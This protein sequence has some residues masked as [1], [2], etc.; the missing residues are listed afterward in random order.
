VGIM[1]R[2]NIARRVWS[3]WEGST[4]VGGKTSIELGYGDTSSWNNMCENCLATRRPFTMPESYTLTNNGAIYGGNYSNFEA[5]QPYSLFSSANNDEC[6]SNRILGSMAYLQSKDFLVYGTN[7]TAMVT[8]RRPSCQS[9][10]HVL[11]FNGLT[12]SQNLQGAGGSNGPVM[13]FWLGDANVTSGNV[14]EHVTSITNPL[15]NIIASDW[16]VTNYIKATSVSSVDSQ[17]AN[18]FTGTAGAQLC[19]R[20]VNG[21]VT[22]VPLWPWP[23]NERIRAATTM[24]GAYSGPCLNCSGGRQARVVTDVTADVEAMLGTIPSQCRTSGSPTQGYT[25]CGFEYEHCNFQG[26]KE[27]RYGADGVFVSKILTDGT[28]CTNAV[29][30]DPVFGATKYC[31]FRDVV[32]PLPTVD[33]IAPTVTI[34]SPP[35][36]TVIQQSQ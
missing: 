22:S 6:D 21:A 12:S 27:V 8:S 16:R 2:N 3:R 28:P 23:M 34:I 20:Y 25:F 30:G 9:F 4:Q 1:S 7:P 35:N 29:F 13:S 18:P 11:T 19:Y 14:L 10:R 5:E 17:G 24:A 32:T 31:E 26:T 36:G 33:S 15:V